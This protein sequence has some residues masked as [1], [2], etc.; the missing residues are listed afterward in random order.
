M[1]AAFL[2]FVAGFAL[3]AATVA[4]SVLYALER[5]RPPCSR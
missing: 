1:I 3:G 4:G 5:D 2:A